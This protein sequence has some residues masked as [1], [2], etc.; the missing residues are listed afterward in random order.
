VGTIGFG[1][2][3]G[4]GDVTGRAVGTGTGDSGVGNTGTTGAGVIAIGGEIDDD[5]VIVK[6]T[7]II[8]TTVMTITHIRLDETEESLLE[9]LFHFNIF[10]H[11]FQFFLIQF[12]NLPFQ[13]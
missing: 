6:I 10:S 1:G 7:A 8:T 9:I 5:N 12:L 4:A 11:P 13:V 2:T 3:A